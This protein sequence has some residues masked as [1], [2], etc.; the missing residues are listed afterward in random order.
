VAVMA[1]Q[2]FL[3][4]EEA[5][6]AIEST[7]SQLVSESRAQYA[8][9]VDRSGYVIAG[10][11]QPAHMHPEELGAIAAGILSAMQVVVNLAESQETTVKFHS[12]TMANFHFYWVNARVFLLIA[13]DQKQTT[14]SLVRSKA[15]R[16]AKAINPHLAQDDTQRSEIG[17]GQFIEDKLSELFQDL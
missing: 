4:S 2:Y 6:K 15:L 1:R 10:H 8:Q 5:I 14:E 11:G 9:V 12:K 16:T 17:S 3:L 7:L 13:F